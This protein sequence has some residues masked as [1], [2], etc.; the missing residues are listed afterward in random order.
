[1]PPEH[2]QVLHLV[3]FKA[4]NPFRIRRRAKNK[5]A[6][7]FSR[8]IDTYH[9]PQQLSLCHCENTSSTTSFM[10]FGKNLAHLSIP[11]WKVYN[12]EYNDLKATI[13]DLTRQKSGDM[14]H[15]HRKFLDNFDYLNLFVMTKAGELERRLKVD[16]AKFMTIKRNSDENI[17]DL[18]AR[19]NSLHYD[20]INEI[21]LEV[22]KLTKFIVVQKIAVKKIF[23]KLTK[24][25]PD[26]GASKAFV[27]ELMQQLQC[28]PYSF[29]NF[30]LSK[31]TTDLT[32][33][34]NEI[35]SELRYLLE[36]VRKGSSQAHA[37]LLKKSHSG[38]TIKSLRGSLFSQ[39]SG[40]DDLIVDAGFGSADQIAKF[41]L[42]TVLKKNF[43]V[44]SLVPQDISSRNDL[45]LTLDVFLTIPMISDLRKISIIY[46]THPLSKD[47]SWIIS[48]KDQPLSIVMAF[49][50]G[51]R[52]YSYC[53][54]LHN[55][56]GII[57]AFLNEKEIEDKENLRK[58]ISEYITN[59]G[60]SSMTRSILDFMLNCNLVPSLQLV[61]DRSRYFLSQ[62][63]SQHEDTSVVDKSLA[64]LTPNSE[65]QTPSIDKKVYEDSFY[66]ILDENIFTTNHIASKVSFN[67]AQMDSFPFNSFSIY[68][69]DSHLHSFEDQLVTEI[70]GNV[71]RSKP[72]ISALN[73]LP[74]KIQNLFKSAPI[75]AFKGFL[76]YDYMNSCYS[77]MIP[78][79]PNNH[80][81]RL[82]NLNL[83]KNYENIE[84]SNKQEMLD[85]T[86]IQ[87][88]SKL[89][90]NRQ[91]SCNSMFPVQHT[92]KGSVVA[93]TNKSA[94]VK[95]LGACESPV[96]IQSTDYPSPRAS[97]LEN[98]FEE[99]VSEDGYLMYL[100]FQNELDDNIF[101]RIIL[102]FVKI[103]YRSLRAFRA[104]NLMDNDDFRWKSKEKKPFDIYNE[105][106]Y[107]SINEE[108]T[109]FNHD[110]DYQIQFMTD[111]D[112]VVSF[113][114]FSLCFSSVF[115]MGIN[116]GIL[117][118][119]LNFQGRETRLSISDNPI[120]IFTLFVGFL[121]ALIF[122]MG[123]INLHFQQFKTPP[124]LHSSILWVSLVFVNFTVMWSIAQIIG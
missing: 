50:G 41:D 104:F 119:L 15:L 94:S 11:E 96:V 120:L 82:L 28:N 39:H 122:S 57:L 95:S 69:N 54:L 89:I 34:L 52:K 45:S 18:L 115:I 85:K 30:D 40:F 17:A 27:A 79:N 49:T 77:N 86:I 2:V 6:R 44:H 42:I 70:D 31:V 124:V 118:S 64:P 93:S 46:L 72:P 9:P 37:N 53:C 8:T 80:Y 100:G 26:P 84:I 114:S 14:T 7:P 4:V 78:E 38:S 20:V 111:Y 61:F 32:Y 113:L 36:H 98:Y 74:C 66:M 29:I 23:K 117:C 109:Y 56:V 59:G 87:S 116:L 92:P 25:Y 71:L 10:K 105:A 103:K 102:A 75:H 48:Y 76:I 62:Q 67:T 3:T 21:S 65:P 110:N 73:K 99:N 68:S 108:P 55:M 123:S 83:L 1:M 97:D 51:L 112:S 106:V 47:P 22:R 91:Q 5:S 33:L 24:H 43:S 13:R 121:F 19:L 81:S 16:T 60:L 58:Q 35:D 90:L 63:P 12:L 88:R 101:N 107:D